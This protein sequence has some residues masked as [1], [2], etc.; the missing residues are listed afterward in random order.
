MLEGGVCVWGVMGRTGGGVR[1]AFKYFPAP[2]VFMGY[3]GQTFKYMPVSQALAPFSQM[4]IPEFLTLSR[5]AGMPFIHL[6][7]WQI[8][9]RNARCRK[10]GRKTRMHEEA[11][12]F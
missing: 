9:M 5:R 12:F 11:F 2:T 6:C 10:D 3:E 8:L 4:F 7:V 1:K